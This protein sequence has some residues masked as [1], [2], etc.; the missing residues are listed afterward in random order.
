MELLSRTGMG[1]DINRHYYTIA[2]IET[3]LR[4]PLVQK[5]IELIRLRNTHP[6]F[7][8]E[9]HVEAPEKNLLEMKWDRNEHWI[10]LN[11]DLFVPAASITGS[12]LE[13]KIEYAAIP[14]STV[15]SFDRRY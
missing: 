14:K 11:L 2:E 15:K 5:L 7:G 13:E 12:G 9:F 10:K 8:G 3:A 6:A 4:R 1:R